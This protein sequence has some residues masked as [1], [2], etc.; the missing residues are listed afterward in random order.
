MNVDIRAVEPPDFVSV[1]RPSDLPVAV[2]RNR[3]VATRKRMKAAGLDVLLVY[4][5]REHS[6]NMAYLTGFDPRFEEAVLLLGHDDRA[7]L[8]VGNECMGY[9]P[10]DEL[11]LDVELFQPLSLMGQ[12]RD[13]SRPLGEILRDF[14]IGD[15]VR[16]GCVGWKS[17]SA[18]PALS[19][20]EGL[21]E[22]PDHACE[23]PAYLVDALRELTGD[24]ANV[25][26]ANDIFMDVENGLR[27]TN[28]IEQIVWFEYA[29]YVSSTGVLNALRA[30]KPGVAEHDLERHY[31]G[32][33]LTRSCHPMVGFGDKAKRGLASPS[34]RKAKSGDPFTLA[35][36]V[37]GSLTARAGCVARGKEDLSEDLRSFYEDFAKNYFA[38][39]AA[40]Y[41][42]VKVGAVA[43]DVAAAAEEA[44]DDRLYDFCVNTG[45]YLHLDE[46]LNSPFTSGSK[47]KLRSGMMIQMDIIPM[48]KGPFCCC[49]VEDGI[50]LA[51]EPLRAK[52]AERYPDMWT[53]VRGRRRFMRESI[54]IESDDSVLPL[55]AIPAWL[56]PYALDLDRAMVVTAN[57]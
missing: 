11:G 32:R 28:E 40:W 43:G 13:S 45:H 30:L 38:V 4:G 16:V 6:A 46:W 51:D 34:A 23:I 29:A 12:A 5:D 8:L 18:P 19:T 27:V 52:I 24:P 26:N 31:D 3:I 47:V 1:E 17:Y 15:G 20:A 22:D 7:K 50:V 42:N 55:S 53:R 54:G 49:N 25:V 48:S 14:G 44:R 57:L 36:G 56:P 9:L 35:L 21:A 39:V 41:K 2:Y 33:G 10:P 37:A